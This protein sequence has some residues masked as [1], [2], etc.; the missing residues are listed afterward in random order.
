MER[1][2]RMNGWHRMADYL[3]VAACHTHIHL[4]TLLASYCMQIM[5]PKFFL[6]LVL[7]RRTNNEGV[8]KMSVFVY[9]ST[10]TAYFCLVGV[11]FWAFIIQ[12]SGHVIKHTFFFYKQTN[13]EGLAL[14]QGLIEL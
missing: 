10:S 13:F 6:E 1:R 11:C 4:L 8:L 7:E 12:S 5:N 2:A 9:A 14:Y 3:R